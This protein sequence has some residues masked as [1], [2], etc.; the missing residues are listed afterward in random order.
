VWAWLTS[1][2]SGGVCVHG[3]LHMQVRVAAVSSNKTVKRRGGHVHV[4]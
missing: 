3:S 2:A 1:Y 4:H